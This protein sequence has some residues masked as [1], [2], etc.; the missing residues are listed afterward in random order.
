MNEL[1]S[2]YGQLKVIFL[3]L[4]LGCFSGIYY[5]ICKYIICLTNK[6]LKYLVSFILFTF[7]LCFLIYFSL[8]HI[9]I[10]FGFFAIIFFFLGL[11]LY[12][13]L[14]DSSFTITLDKIQ[15]TLKKLN[16]KSLLLPS[17]KFL[18]FIKRKKTMKKPDEKSGS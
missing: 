12:Y 7:L 18:K 8:Y 15:S 9:R 10:Y 4:L 14:L 2:F 13:F 11:L 6:Y 17:F 5:K 1:I 3:Y 16:I